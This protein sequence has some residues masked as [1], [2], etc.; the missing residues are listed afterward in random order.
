[1]VLGTLYHLLSP[2]ATSTHPQLSSLALP[3]YTKITKASWFSWNSKLVANVIAL[4][5]KQGQTEEAECLISQ[6]VSTICSKERDLVSFYCNL[7]DSHIKLRSEHGFS[8]TYARLKEI[9]STSPSVYVRKR[10]SESLVGGLCVMG[11]PHEAET[12]IKEMRNRGIK[13]SLFEFRS[14]VE[15]YGRLVLFE[16]M[17]QSVAEMEK[18]GFPLDTISSNMVI[19]SYGMHNELSQMV[20]W[21]QK[22]KSLRVSFSVRT[23]NSVLNA[24]PTVMSL[25]QDLKNVVVSL[26]EL[27]SML[28]GDEALLVKE[29]LGSTVLDDVMRWDSM[30]M[31]LDFH[32]M[33]LSTS[34]LI[35]LQWMQEVC[36][37]LTSGKCEIPAVVTLVCGLGKHSSV[38]GDSPVKGLVREI[39]V[40]TRSPLRI[41]RKNVG[42]FV[43]KG[44]AVKD[45]LL[46]C[47]ETGTSTQTDTGTRTENVN[48]LKFKGGF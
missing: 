36:W 37:R 39:L 4:L 41:D 43:A 12:L 17:L 10:A 47:T 24:C 7:I 2:Q 16:E 46:S 32:G 3:L 22:V 26:E 40:R 42:C 20:V 29:L 8:L 28:R 27:L 30:E 45:W 31:K 1:M 33:H 18:N 6:T 25:L 34:Y 19:S 48:S 11:R 35:L 14:M 44:K 21:V 13:L 23:Y 9:F 15:G 5:Y 38:R